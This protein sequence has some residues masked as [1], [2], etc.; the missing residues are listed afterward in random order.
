MLSKTLLH[1]PPAATAREDSRQAPNVPQANFNFLDAQAS[2]PED[3]DTFEV[4]WRQRFLE[5]IGKNDSP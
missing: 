4:R 5:A 3:S 1:W 2:L